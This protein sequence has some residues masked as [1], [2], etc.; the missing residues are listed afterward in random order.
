[1]RNI[2]IQIKSKFDN[3]DKIRNLLKEKEAEYLGID[4]QSDTYF[5]VRSG[6]LK[7]REGN[8]E[9]KLMYEDDENDEKNDI[10]LYKTQ[11]NSSLKKILEKTYGIFEI[12]EKHREI[13]KI[14]NVKFYIDF[15]SQIGH[16]IGI[17]A[18][19]K[20]GSH[21][22][23][24]LLEQCEYYINLFGFKQWKFVQNSYSDMVDQLSD[25]KNRHAA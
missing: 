17:E 9:N 23:E 19:G 14:G 1:M 22:K 10:L 5:N 25:V 16:T 21:T 15:T 3:H 2:N 7:L 6:T 8:L 20:D 24:Q 13:Y 11:K 12:I 4:F 18:I